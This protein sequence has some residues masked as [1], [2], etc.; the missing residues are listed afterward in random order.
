MITEF[1]ESWELLGYTYI[2]GW[3]LAV[4]LPLSG[5]LVVAR[6]QIFVGAALS[7]A[8]TLGI[9][10][11]LVVGGEALVHDDG[12]TGTVLP[13]SLAVICSVVAAVVIGRTR[14]ETLAAVTGWTFL[15]GASGS[16]LLVA[17]SPFG[18]EEVH[19]TL[20][21]TILAVDERDVWISGLFVIASVVAALTWRRPLLLIAIDPPMASA[22]GLRVRAWSLGLSVALGLVIGFSLRASGL[23]YTFGMLVLPA[24]AAKNLVRDASWMFLVAPIIGVMTSVVGFVLA[25]GYDFPPGQMTVAIASGVVVV[26]WIAKA[27]LVR[28]A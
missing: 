28:S 12:S 21:S 23:I 15:L 11:A 9:A 27:T 3:F 5:V 4:L 2:V 1:L 14:R 20:F 25:H 7:Q 22:V 13:T 24:L 19:K 6:D 16:I 10:I 8:S 17:S 18:V 26:A